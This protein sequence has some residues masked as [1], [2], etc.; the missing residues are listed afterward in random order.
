MIKIF[1][2]TSLEF[3]GDIVYFASYTIVAS[4]GSLQRSSEAYVS[5]T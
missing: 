3:K 4:D 1:N 2:W 5:K